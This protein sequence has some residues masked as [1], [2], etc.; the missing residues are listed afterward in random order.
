MNCEKKLYVVVRGDLEPGL[1]AAQSCHAL[2]QFVEE[3]PETDQDWFKTSN[4][5]VLLEVPDVEEL[6]E[7]TLVLD[8][9]DIKYARFIEPDLGHELTAIAVA[10]EGRP[11]CSRFRLAFNGET[12][13][14]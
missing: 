10:P 7:L 3:H 14:T 1:R 11:H 9:R 13:V 6:A 2:R 4:T 12:H 5:F 8:R